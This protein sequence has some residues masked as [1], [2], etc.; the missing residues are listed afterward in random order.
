[1]RHRRLIAWIL[2]GAAAMIT[3]VR[4]G[5]MIA[6]ASE[7]G[8]TVA[9]VHVGLWESLLVVL[10]IVSCA[11]VLW[12]YSNRKPIPSSPIAGQLANPPIINFLF[13]D[14]DSAP[15][16]AVVRFY[17][18]FA[19]LSAGYGK[20]RDQAW[21]I[22]GTALKQFWMMTTAPSPPESPPQRTYDWYHAFLTFM[23]HNDWFTWLAKVIA[24]GEVV[25]GVFLL[26]GAFVGIVSLFGA[27]LNFNYALAGS[28]GAN[29]VLLI[30]GSLLVT[31]W[32]VSGYIG[33]DRYLLPRLG[34]PWHR[35]RHGRHRGSQS[36]PVT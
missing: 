1:M 35:V 18:G 22:S 6:G 10:Q 27:V 9:S 5:T 30:M 36:R 33:L 12:I 16:W 24:V 8:S 25:V 31:A 29:T 34:T 15:L 7:P 26:C 19:W 13:G 4:I 28:A 23:L 14:K 20:I 2:V 21:M 32:M 17:V 11:F 3:A